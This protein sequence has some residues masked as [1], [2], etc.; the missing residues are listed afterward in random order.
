M[1]EPGH[2]SGGMAADLRSYVERIEQLEMHKAE[3]AEDIAAVYAEA[4]ARGYALKPLRAII[5]MRKMSDR[6]REEHEA[7]V[8]IYKA[9]LGMLNDTPL[10]A[11]A[12]R[13]LNP[14]PKPPG[15]PP[16]G[17][18][19]G[20]SAPP[21]PRAPAPASPPDSSAQDGAEAPV[22]ADPLAAKTVDDARA[23]GAI[24]AANGQPV[25]TNPFA[26]GDPRRAAFDEAWCQASGSD[27]ME[28]PAAWRRTPKAPKKPPE[29]PA[30][31][32]AGAGA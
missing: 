32:D 8:D 16:P 21:L 27:G 13:R 18:G 22:A 28:I 1:A 14:A 25:A 11:A 26:A 2:N 6:E 5:R 4:G 10:G 3:I 31:G 12:L 17:A 30:S 24:A 20:A 15:A 29:A 19:G 9:A 7:L 23:M